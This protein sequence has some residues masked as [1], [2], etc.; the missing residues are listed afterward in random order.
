MDLQMA[1]T[2]VITSQMDGPVLEGTGTDNMF[3]WMREESREW[4]M[5]QLRE[6]TR[7]QCACDTMQTSVPRGVA[8]LNLA[9]VYIPR[10]FSWWAV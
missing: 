2:Q 9:S 1:V 10:V 5:A 6:Q 4:G 7:L 3:W 8:S